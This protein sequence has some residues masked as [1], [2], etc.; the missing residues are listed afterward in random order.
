MSVQD[1]GS[2]E[3]TDFLLAEEAASVGGHPAWQEILNAVPEQYHEALRPTLEKWDKGVQNRFQSLHSKYEPIKQYA[4]YSPEDLEVALNLKQAV[5]ADPKA[6]WELL[7]QTYN[8]SLE[9]GAT[10]GEIAMN[11]D[12]DEFEG[13]PE[14]YQQLQLTQQ[15]LME[16]QE[17]LVALQQQQDLE[18]AEEELDAYMAYLHSEHGDFDDDYVVTLLANGVDGDEAVN[19][20]QQIVQRAGGTKP[21]PAAPPKVMSAG[22]GVPSR[23]IDP[24]ALSNSDTKDLV[25]QMLLQAQQGE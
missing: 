5:E 18:K 14:L 12:P 3:G 25:A 19:R 8:F 6:V 21:A 2:D 15:Q 20:Y 17:A 1:P 4:D 13:D 10:E 7:A 11:F 24:K 22:G 23:A 9:Q 16:Q